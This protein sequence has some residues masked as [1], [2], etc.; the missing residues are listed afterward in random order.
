MANLIKKI[1]TSSGDLQIDYN[2]LANLPTISNPNLLIN[3]DFRNPINQRGST[4]YPESGS[5]VYC[6]DRWKYF[7]TM[8]VA[9]QSGTVKLAS[10]GTGQSWFMQEFEMALPSETYT[11]SIKVTSVSGT[12]DMKFENSSGTQVEKVI[13]STGVTTL[14]YTGSVGAIVFELSGSGSQLTIEWVKLEAGAIATSFF[15]RPVAEEYMLCRRYFDVI[16]GVRTIGV[17]QSGDQKTITYSIPITGKMAKAPTVSVR[18][19]TTTN[20]TDGIC[21]RDNWC[22]MY[23]GLTFTYAARPG[24]ITVNATS[25]SAF[26]KE[27]YATQLYISDNFK[28]CLD[29]EIY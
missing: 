25:S 13:S 18:G 26:D 19:I 4:T 8:T 11:L 24:E 23:S 5:W 17:E 14:T 27:S 20:S 28:I 9:V 29:A 16:S 1:R 10:H 3:S 7:N 15:P 21:V 22:M 6:I 12:C 2:A